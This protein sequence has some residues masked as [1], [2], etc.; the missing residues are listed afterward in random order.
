MRCLLTD[1]IWFKPAMNYYGQTGTTLP[2][3]S[4]RDSDEAKELMHGSASIRRNLNAADV[5]SL[6]CLVNPGFEALYVNLVFLVLAL[7]RTHS[8]SAQ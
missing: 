7:R 1:A 3:P 6:Q 5:S 8:F 4:R 2:S